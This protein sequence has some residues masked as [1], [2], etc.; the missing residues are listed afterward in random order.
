MNRT[1]VCSFCF[2][3]ISR[4]DYLIYL[5]YRYCLNFRNNHHHEVD[6][7]ICGYDLLISCI[8]EEG[9][10]NN[11]T[12]TL[13]DSGQARIANVNQ[14]IV[15]I[16]GIADT[17]LNSIITAIVLQLTNWLY[18]LIIIGTTIIYI[19]PIMPRISNVIKAV[20]RKSALIL[21]GIFMTLEF[22]LL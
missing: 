11:L 12:T 13:G 17:D 4:W 3:S 22:M 8:N 6:L 1:L 5:N 14:N 18:H 16:L 20:F 2:F 7:V 15:W 9:P 19:L 10:C 21:S